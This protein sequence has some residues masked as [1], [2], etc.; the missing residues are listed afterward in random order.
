MIYYGDK[1]K[2]VDFDKTEA[3]YETIYGGHYNECKHEMQHLKTGYRSV[4]IYHLN[5]KR[6]NT[7]LPTLQANDQ[8]IEKL[9]SLLNKVLY[10]LN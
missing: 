10:E 6:Q 3:K 7:P 4:L 8:R 9:A 5:W 1:S 2:S